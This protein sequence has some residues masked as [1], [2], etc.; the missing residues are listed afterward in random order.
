MTQKLFRLR[1]GKRRDFKVRRATARAE[2]KRL[3]FC[4]TDWTTR[5][6]H[7]KEACNVKKVV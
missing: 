3:I 7:E 2:S 1:E 5:G 4:N 6:I